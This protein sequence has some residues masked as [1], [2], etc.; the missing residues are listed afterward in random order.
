MLI[1]TYQN[2]KSKF[3]FSMISQFKKPTIQKK[4]LKK[5]SLLG[6]NMNRLC[7]SA[8]IGVDSSIHFEIS[9]FL[10]FPI[11]LLLNCPL[12]FFSN[13]NVITLT[14]NLYFHLSFLHSDWCWWLNWNS[15]ILERWMKDLIKNNT[16][17]QIKL[18]QWVSI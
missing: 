3:W 9:F 18:C 16:I 5:S 14:K 12:H 17:F 15:W 1:A 2:L 11:C 4:F 6:M 8:L 10:S 13:L 7:R